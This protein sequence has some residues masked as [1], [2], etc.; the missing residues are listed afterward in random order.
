MALTSAWF[1]TDLQLQSAA[2]N[3]P[4]LRRGS[5]GGG[6]ARLQQA[7]VQLGHKLPISVKPDGTADG[8]FGGETDKAVRQ[9]QEKKGLNVDG[10]AG[11]D[12]ITTMDAELAGTF[13]GGNMTATEKKTLAADLEL[14]RQTARRCTLLLVVPMT[15]PASPKAA[16]PRP[17]SLQQKVAE[18]LSDTFDIDGSD[19]GQVALIQKR[20][21]AFEGRSQVLEFEKT[22]KHA[23]KDQSMGHVAFVEYRLGQPLANNTVFLTPAYFA[24]KD[25]AERARTLLHEFVHLF[26]AGPG[27]PGPDGSPDSGQFSLFSRGRMGVPFEHALFNPY[28]YEYFAKWSEGGL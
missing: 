9:Y 10:V 26:N 22:N 12:T 18:L 2:E 16:P 17:G 27:H 7:L 28:C 21:M 15:F 14:A 8:M 5:N 13:P 6:V 19:R 11:R 4:P 24:E 20:F 23:P 3:A 25:A 1:A